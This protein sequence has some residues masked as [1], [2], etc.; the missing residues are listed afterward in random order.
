M[1]AELK[2]VQSIIQFLPLHSGLAG[3]EK[4]SS[5]V[6]LVDFTVH[7]T[8]RCDPQNRQNKHCIDCSVQEGPQV[9]NLKLEIQWYNTPAT[10]CSE[11]KVTR[12]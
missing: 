1:N 9:K 5:T 7:F 12:K 2:T 11:N 3:L 10:T 6:D 4:M 8:I